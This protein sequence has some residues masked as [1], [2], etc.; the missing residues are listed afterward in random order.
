MKPISNRWRTRGSNARE[1]ARAETTLKKLAG[2]S[3][4]GDYYFKLGAMYGNDER[5]KESK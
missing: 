3:E 2:T 5:W 4:K 1:S